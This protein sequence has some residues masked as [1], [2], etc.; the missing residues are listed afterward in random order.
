MS[1]ATIQVVAGALYD[2]H[3][4]VLI[5]QRPPGKVMAGR[6]EFPGGKLHAAEDAYDGL[7]R[8]LREE[9]GI[10]VHAAE[11]LMRYAVTSQDRQVWLD[12]WIVTAWSGTVAGLE[13]Q[14]WKWVA[15]AAL[16]AEDILE[17]DQPIVDA[18]VA[19]PAPHFAAA[20]AR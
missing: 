2:A 17:A 4:R 3:G 15:P 10:D 1:H 13:G 16:P 7:V 8:E 9:L 14:A 20:A 11:R 5:T 6:W 19:R 12:M 18:L